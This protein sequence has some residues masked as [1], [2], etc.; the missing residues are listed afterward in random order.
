[1]ITTYSQN[2]VKGKMLLVGA[3]LKMVSC[4][5]LVIKLPNAQLPVTHFKHKKKVIFVLSSLISREKSKDV[6]TDQ[7]KVT[8]LACSSMFSCMF[9]LTERV[10]RL[11]IYLR[12]KLLL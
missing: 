12:H 2:C 9:F 5:I 11:Y 7:P 1:M 6:L 3:F 4:C 10:Y 8:A